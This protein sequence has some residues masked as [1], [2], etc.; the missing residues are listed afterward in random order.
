MASTTIYS[1][2]WWVGLFIPG[3]HGPRS[4][5]SLLVT[6]VCCED[7]QRILLQNDSDDPIRWRQRPHSRIP[8]IPGQQQQIWLSVLNLFRSFAI[9]LCKSFYRSIQLQSSK[10]NCRENSHGTQ[11]M[12]LVYR[13]D[14]HTSTTISWA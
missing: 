10:Y 12:V 14:C 8:R 3:A 5:R 7:C 6:R 9:L 1:S 4:R 11:I 13:I 2:T